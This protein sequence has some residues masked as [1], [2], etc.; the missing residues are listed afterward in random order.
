MKRIVVRIMLALFLTD[1]FFVTLTPI[2]RVA[3][4]CYEDKSCYVMHSYSICTFEVS[5]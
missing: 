4:T 1:I 3:K 2:S 5:V